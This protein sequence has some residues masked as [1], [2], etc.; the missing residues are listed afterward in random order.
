M[1]CVE[2]SVNRY[3]SRHVYTVDSNIVLH[4]FT[5]NAA[6]FE[7]KKTHNFINA[8][9]KIAERAERKIVDLFY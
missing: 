7:R 5:K 1:Q 4:Y 8:D 3:I 2:T 6:D 9:T